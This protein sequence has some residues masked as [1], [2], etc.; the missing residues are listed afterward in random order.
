MPLY[1]YRCLKCGTRVEK[2]R[3]FSD[4]PFTKCEKCGGKLEQLL[5]SPAFQ[6]KGTGWYVTD[7]G[8]KSSD[9]DKQKAEKDK[10]DSMPASAKDEKT[11]KDQK[12]TADKTVKTSSSEPSKSPEPSGKTKSGDTKPRTRK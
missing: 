7:Y 3:K 4:P 6:F 1:E 12:S 9:G 2:I 10:S 5:S 11:A 8:G